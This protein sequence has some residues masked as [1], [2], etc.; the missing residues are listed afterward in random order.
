MRKPYQRYVFNDSDVYEW[1]DAPAWTMIFYHDEELKRLVD[2][3]YHD[4][5]QC[6]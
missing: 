1:L 3:V 6:S 2:P 4:S 5:G